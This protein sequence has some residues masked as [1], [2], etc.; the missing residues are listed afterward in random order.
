[1]SIEAKVILDSISPHGQR[2]TTVEVNIHRFILAE[3]NTHRQF[4][5]SAQSSRAIPVKKMIERILEDPA[6]PVEWGK[7]IAGMQ[8]K[9]LLVNG[10]AVQAELIWRQAMQSAVEFAEKLMYLGVHKQLANRLIEPFMWQ[11]VIISSTEWD[12]FF[13]LRAHPDAQPEF[14]EVAYK[15]LEAYKNSTPQIL[16]YGD[17]HTPYITE[18]EYNELDVE[19]RKNVSVAR[20]ARVS[21]LNNDGTRDL[22]KDLE[23][24]TR[25]DTTEPK[26][27]APC[28]HVAT[29]AKTVWSYDFGGDHYIDSDGEM[30]KGNFRG[31]EQY[32]HILEGLVVS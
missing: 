32:R 11:R 4:S 31:W 5:R 10:E 1:V 26:H 6:I 27:S 25:L 15:I 23:L 28:E 19:A 13:N 24:F 21:Y 17:W 30:L 16:D 3:V 29:P 9:E 2:L 12:N 7:N 20:C 14:R 22:E 18:E 8:S